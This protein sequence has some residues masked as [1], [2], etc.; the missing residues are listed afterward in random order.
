MRI[1]NRVRMKIVHL[2]LKISVIPLGL[3]M[4]AIFMLPGTLIIYPFYMLL[5]M[6]FEMTI[7][8]SI[9][10]SC[11]WYY[12]LLQDITFSTHVNNLIYLL[13]DWW[14]GKSYYNKST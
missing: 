6:S 14:H 8:F 1:I 5:G 9:I 4:C 3:F 12:W 13:D 10:I 7:T 11:I 2:L